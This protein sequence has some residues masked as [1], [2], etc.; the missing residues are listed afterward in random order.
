MLILCIF[1]CGGSVSGLLASFIA[2]KASRNLNVVVFSHE[3]DILGIDI[4]PIWFKRSDELHS[5]PVD[6]NTITATNSRV[7]TLPIFPFDES[8]CFPTS[9]IDLHIFVMK[10]RMM[11]NDIQGEDKMFGIV[12]SDGKGRICEIG[13]AA[14]VIHR[15]LLPDGRQLLKNI[16]RQRFRVLEIIQDEPYMVAK[17]EYGVNDIEISNAEESGTG[18]LPSELQELEKD[19]FQVY[20][21]VYI[22]VQK[23]LQSS[24]V[25]NDITIS[26][27]ELIGDVVIS[28]SPSKHPF[29]LQVASDFSFAMCET[30]NIKSFEL[31]QVLLQTESLQKRL[32][33]MRKILS[34]ARNELASQFPNCFEPFN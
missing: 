3:S 12:L 9:S 27:S 5:S 33:H 2:P 17:V 16:C 28:L 21:D 15:E 34:A 4:D 7:R 8:L 14:E 26:T 6:I 1:I 18:E 19:V 29:R 30:M 25:K 31:R 32:N 13:T 10:Y 22:L 24:L 20:N 11:M 23:I